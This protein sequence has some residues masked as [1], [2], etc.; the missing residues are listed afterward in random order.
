[1]KHII[2]EQLINQFREYLKYEEKSNATIEKYIRDI[3][4]LM[5]FAGGREITKKLML[6][7]KE[8]LRIN[9]NY[10]LSSINSFLI[11][12]NRLFGYLEWYG[13]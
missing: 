5:D 11:A 13:L 9:Q 6:E 3:K 2:T 7:Y 4:K 12:A 1:M 10:K 8:N